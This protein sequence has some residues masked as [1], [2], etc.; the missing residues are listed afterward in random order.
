M[1][2]WRLISHVLRLFH[3]AGILHLTLGVDVVRYNHG[4]HKKTT[5]ANCFMKVLKMDTETERVYGFLAGM[6]AG[7]S[8]L[9]T[10]QLKALLSHTGG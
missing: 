8:T 5:P 7:H 9:E 4:T 6:A 10:K 2:V 3:F 1:I